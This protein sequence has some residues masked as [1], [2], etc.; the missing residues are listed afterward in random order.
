MT[1]HSPGSIG[2]WEAATRTLFSG[3]AVY[4]G[5]LLDDLPDSDVAEYVATMQRLRDVPARVVH[6]GHAPSFGRERL[7]EPADGYLSSRA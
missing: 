2:L 3:D 7:V 4:D 6:G 1:G 5:V